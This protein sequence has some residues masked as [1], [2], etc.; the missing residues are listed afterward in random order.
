MKAIDFF[1]ITQYHVNM[2]LQSPENDQKYLIT[3]IIGLVIY[4]L[5]VR[6]MS[7][8]I[9]KLLTE[10]NAFMT[11]KFRSTSSSELEKLAKVY[12]DHSKRQKPPT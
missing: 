1:H 5:F 10:F 6:T 4:H 8:V 12:M 9:A 11:C 3:C 7:V 2:I